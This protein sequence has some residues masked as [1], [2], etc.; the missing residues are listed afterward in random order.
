LRSIRF[1]KQPLIACS[2]YFK[3]LFVIGPNLLE[4]DMRIN[5]TT[6]KMDLKL[7]KLFYIYIHCQK[8]VLEDSMSLDSIKTLIELADYYMLDDLL[9]G[10][11]QYIIDRTTTHEKMLL[12]KYSLSCRITQLQDSLALKLL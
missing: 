9:R 10:C 3:Q 4:V 11:Q 5:E 1:A 2:P 12:L 8:V 6:A 7:L